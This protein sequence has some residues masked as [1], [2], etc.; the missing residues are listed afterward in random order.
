MTRDEEVRER[1][2]KRFLEC[3]AKRAEARAYAMKDGKSDE[4][5][6][7][8]AHEVAK[9][10]WNAW[11][12]E[13]LAE[14]KALEARGAWAAELSRSQEPKNAETR[15][16]M[17]EAEASFSQCLF[18][19]QG[20]E[21]TKEAPG[22][23]KEQPEAGELPVKSIVIDDWTIDFRGFVFPGTAQFNSVTFRTQALFSSATFRETARFD[24]ATFEGDV[25][26]DSVIFRTDALFDSATFRN[27][28]RFDN[29]TFQGDAWF[30]DAFLR[31]AATFKSATQFDRTTFKST[32]RFESAIFED[33]AQ[34]VS[35]TFEGDA[36]FACSTFQGNASFASATF[37]FDARFDGATLKGNAL[38]ERVIFNG[39]VQFHSATFERAALFDR[40]IFRGTVQFIGATFEGVAWFGRTTFKDDAWFA[41]ATFS[42]GTS[43]RDAKF[44]SEEKKTDADFTAIKVERA[45]DLTGAYFSKMPSFCQADFKQAP[46]LD[47]VS[48]PL[49]DAEPF[50]SGDSALIPKYRAIRRMAIQGADYDR[51]QR[52]F[53][54]ELRSR[55]WTT[56]KWWHPSLWL[57][58]VYDGVADCG[59]SI[60]QPF[61]VWAA[62]II[63][64][65][66][67]Y[68]SR[69]IPGAETRCAEGDGPFVQALYLSV[70]NALVLFAGTRDARVNQA[71]VCLY[72]GSP[73]HPHIPASVT[74][75]E[76]LLQFPMSAT[77][78]F[79]FLLAVKNRF[80]IK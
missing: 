10:H 33:D 48:F 12:E 76:T 71:Y 29:A 21:G 31:S 8:V 23:H 42:K 13:K 73:E 11:A 1:T 6:R 2:V 63:A 64:F 37:S 40:A 67:F 7:K 70:K 45:F 14:R 62:T 44:S 53:K 75:V 26:F 20:G 39:A 15:A 56:D 47:G 59:R 78:I 46:D 58:I 22:E 79:L 72:N 55:R 43:F 49:P 25:L 52:A 57:G 66:A 60:S 38:F 32:A 69:A 41:G 4:E 28:V 61:G 74:F 19:L 34:F 77:L 9:A 16:W 5:A 24:D 17:E 51:E 30:G 54:G 68:W 50:V 80:K 18:T 35:A 3:E 36:R 27:T 65:A